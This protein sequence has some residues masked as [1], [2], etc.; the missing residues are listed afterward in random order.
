MD[1]VY[2]F[3]NLTTPN[4]RIWMILSSGVQ[5][6][7]YVTLFALGNEDR[8]EFYYLPPEMDCKRVLSCLDWTWCNIDGVGQAGTDNALSRPINA[9]SREQRRFSEGSTIGLEADLYSV[10]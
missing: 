6:E 7:N 8:H 3:P 9:T 5:S 10:L 2:H 4:K 1:Q